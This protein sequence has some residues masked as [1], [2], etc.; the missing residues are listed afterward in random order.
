[1]F[2]D[3]G[4][5]S[6]IRDRPEWLACLDYLRPG[7]TLIV[8]ALSRLAGT[9]TMAIET[10]NDLHE[11][12]INI[13]SLTEPDI[14]TVPAMGRALFAIVAVSPSFVSTRSARTPGAGLSMRA[15]RAGSLVAPRSCHLN[16]RGRSSGARCRRQHIGKLLGVGAAATSRALVRHIDQVDPFDKL[17]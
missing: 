3:H 15:L 8:P 12:G 7:D 13:K 17:R 9:T 11:R 2:V 5:S 10:I 16:G 1:V 4:E 14:D 6:W